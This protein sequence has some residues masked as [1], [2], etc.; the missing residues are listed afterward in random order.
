MESD[1][2]IKEERTVSKEKENNIRE[3]LMIA[4][5]DGESERKSRLSFGS[6]FSAPHPTNSAWLTTFLLL[7]AMI[8]SG[9]LNQPYVFMKSG[10]I[11]ALIAFVIAAAGTFTG[12]LCLT[13]AGMKVNVLEYSGLARKA[14]YKNGDRLVDV[15]IIIE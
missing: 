1:D 13:E 2:G 4:D 10:V 3:N 14:F 6:S 7:N 11:G 5:E 12:L 8:G 15:S 9:I